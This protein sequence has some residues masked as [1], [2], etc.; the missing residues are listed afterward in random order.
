MA[1][2]KNRSDVVQMSATICNALITD[3][4]LSE[5]QLDAAFRHYE[6]LA[7][8]LQFSGARFVEA[9]AEAVRLGNIALGRLRRLRLEAERA[10]K[11]AEMDDGMRE[12][13]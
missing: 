4:P 1:S 8:T 9:R 2:P 12:I 11:V 6:G 10:K 3:A 13:R 5:D 7:G